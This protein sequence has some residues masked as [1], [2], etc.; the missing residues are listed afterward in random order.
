MA[1]TNSGLVTYCKK[2][3]GLPYWFGTYGQKAS[4]ALYLKKK[5][6]YPKYYKAKNFPSQYGKRVHDCAGLIKGY[7]WSSSPTATPKYNAKEDYGATGFYTHAKHKGTI[8]SF[9]KIDGQLVFKGSGSKMTHV[10]VYVGGYVIEAKGHAYGVVKTKFNSSW[11]HWAQCHLITDDTSKPQ[12][13]PAP[14]PAPEPTPEPTPS[15]DKYSAS[16]VGTWQVTA[17][18]GLWMRTAPNKS[19]IICIPY[20]KKV[21]CGGYYQTA[22]DGEWLKVTYDKKTGYSFKEYLK[23]L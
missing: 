19:K 16:Y 18:S 12:P 6:Q 17:H 23:K 22:S 5:K 4:K 3:V 1:K 20:G 11:T 10:G 21:K 13:A 9:K 2:Q 7:L 14:T 8:S 15:A